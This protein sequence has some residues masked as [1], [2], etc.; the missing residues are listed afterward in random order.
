MLLPEVQE[1]ARTTEKFWGWTKNGMFIGGND[2]MIALRFHNGHGYEEVTRELWRRCCKNAKY[3]VDVGTH[4][5]I[6]SLDAFRAGAQKVLSCEPHVVNF[7]RMAL[8]LRYNGFTAYGAFYGAI[9][10]EDRIGTLLCK[11][12]PFV[13]YAAGRMDLHS[14]DA[15]EF[16]VNMRRLDSLIKPE[17][18][19][20]IKVIKIDAENYTPKVING[21]AGIFRA[22]NRPDLIIEC[23][24]SGMGD[25]LKALGYKFWRIWETGQIEEVDDLKPHN[26]NNNYNGTDEDCRNRF[27]SI[28]GLPQEE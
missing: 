25:Q 26:P 28:T 27:A 18:W 11:A 8:N 19:P 6:F 5:G 4:S 21:M 24:E 12:M 1:M 10:D 2:D 9:G 3:V 7:S 14:K 16:P 20:E 15:F 17:Y 23:T 22:G 13:C